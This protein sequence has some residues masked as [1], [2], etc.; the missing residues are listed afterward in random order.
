MITNM[1][2]K[3]AIIIAVALVLKK[4]TMNGTTT[5]TVMFLAIATNVMLT[6]LFA[7]ITATIIARWVQQ[8]QLKSTNY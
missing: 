7:V 4:M 6:E 5:A 3:L 8:K 2:K 1:S